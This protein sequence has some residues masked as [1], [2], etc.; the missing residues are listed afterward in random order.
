MK[1]RL[2]KKVASLIM[3][4]MIGMTLSIPCFAQDSDRVIATYTENLG[5]GITAITTIT[6][7][8]TRSSTSTTKTKDFY[9]SGQYIGR[10]ALQGSF[11]YNGSTSQATGANGV[12]SGANG[13]SYGDQNTWI[14]GNSAYL[15]A[16]LSKS[17]T[18][19]PVNISLSCDAYGNVS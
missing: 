16:A 7:T 3:C 13:W 5:N 18:R 17:G 2:R 10:A 8:V 6:Q 9:S 11:S 14:S 12:G 4:V 19:V 15:S 1:N